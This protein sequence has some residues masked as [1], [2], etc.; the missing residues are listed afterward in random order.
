MLKEIIVHIRF[1]LHTLTF[2]WKRVFKSDLKLSALNRTIDSV[3]R[4]RIGLLSFR[5]YSEALTESGFN[6]KV[7]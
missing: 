2:I 1:R 5:Y 3:S 4:P 7:F 6:L